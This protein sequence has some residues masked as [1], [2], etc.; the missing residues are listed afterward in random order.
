M[1]SCIHVFVLLDTNLNSV[2]YVQR[3]LVIGFLTQ[4]WKD[5]ELMEIKAIEC[6]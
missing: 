6:Y 2:A 1:K 5:L 4:T 3:I